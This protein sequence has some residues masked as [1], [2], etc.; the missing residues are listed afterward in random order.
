MGL[1]FNANEPK[2]SEDVCGWL[3]V[4]VGGGL[5]AEEMVKYA[6]KGCTRRGRECGGL[7]E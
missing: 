6:K 5:T 7:A 3:D 2:L 4:D 1:R